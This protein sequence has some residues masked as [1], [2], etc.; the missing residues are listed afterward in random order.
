M[1]CC[2]R[3]EAAC[4]SRL[5]W[6]AAVLTLLTM[7]TPHLCLASSRLWPAELGGSW[8]AETMPQLW[9]PQ[10]ADQHF[11]DPHLLPRPTELSN[12]GARMSLD[13]GERPAILGMGL[14][15]G[16]PNLGQSMGLD[17]GE[18]PHNL[19]MGRGVGGGARFGERGGSSGSLPELDG[20]VLAGLASWLEVRPGVTSMLCD[21]LRE[22]KS[23]QSHL[24][25]YLLQIVALVLH[26]YRCLWFA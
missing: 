10:L 17:L 3:R 14:G 12:P 9:G 7:P 13:L 11:M 5:K 23:V 6:L 25:C 24:S 19:D 1:Q 22:R 16:G 21:N 4:I 20:G 8:G 15:A 18:R 26:A 2:M